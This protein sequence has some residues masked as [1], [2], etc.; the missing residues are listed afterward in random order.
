[1][2]ENQIYRAFRVVSGVLLFK[3]FTDQILDHVET[4]KEIVATHLR[5]QLISMA[6][7]TKLLPLWNEAIKQIQ[8][9]DTRIVFKMS[10]VNGE[11]CEVLQWGAHKETPIFSGRWKGQAFAPKTKLLEKSPHGCRALMVCSRKKSITSWM[12]LRP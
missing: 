8:E 10:E 1:M 4:E 3:I 7:R 9:Q 5:D 2:T 12:V 11:F 6:D